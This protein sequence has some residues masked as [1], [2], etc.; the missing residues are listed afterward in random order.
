MD[1]NIVVQMLKD[2]GFKRIKLFES[3]SYTVSKF[4]GTDIEVMLGI[5][6]D[7]LHD[8]AKDYDNAKDWVKENVSDH[9]SSEQDKHVN[10]K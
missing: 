9:M 10:I 5:P 4:A 1:P 2:N 7:Q 3:D 8:L 6:N